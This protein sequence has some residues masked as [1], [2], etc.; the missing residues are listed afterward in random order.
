[1]VAAA[2]STVVIKQLLTGGTSTPH[3]L[4]IADAFGRVFPL[5]WL[6]ASRP[7]HKNEFSNKS[8]CG[9]KGTALATLVHLCPSSLPVYLLCACRLE[10]LCTIP[11]VA[12]AS[13]C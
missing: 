7:L 8:T 6:V 12:Q 9:Q 10:T 11:P 5:S 1:M 3:I 13:A 2:P 4:A